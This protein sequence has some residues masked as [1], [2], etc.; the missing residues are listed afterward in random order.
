MLKLLAGTENAIRRSPNARLHVETLLLQWS[1]LDRT[2]ELTEVLNAVCERG[3]KPALPR[4]EPEITGDPENSGIPTIGESARPNSARGPD[5]HPLDTLAKVWPRVVQDV[6]RRR[7]MVREALSHATP[8]SVVEGLVA[9]EVSDCEVHLEGLERNKEMIRQSIED[10]ARIEAKSL[11]YVPKRPDSQALHNEPPA[12]LDRAADQ[13]ERL[14]HH[15]SLD[16][17]LDSL[18]Q[19]LDLEVIE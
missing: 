12:R 7:R 1:L 16:P 19:A 5:E 17:G 4:A 13:E 14:K 11:E 15:R 10:I 9:L 3:P 2:V 8:I 18:A 6:G